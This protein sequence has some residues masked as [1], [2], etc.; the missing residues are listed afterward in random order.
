M[1]GDSGFYKSKPLTELLAQGIDTCIPDSTT[2][3]EL[4][5]D[6][7]IGTLS[8]RSRV[9]MEYDVSLDVFRCAEG[10]TLRF[11]GTKD[12]RGEETKVYEACESCLCCSRR[13]ECI[14]SKAAKT[15]YKHIIVR[16]C[17]E[18]LNAARERFNE[19]GHRE[20]YH[21]RGCMIESVFGF[22]RGAL[23]YDRW[24]LRGTERV[25]NEGKLMALG[26]QFR[27]VHKQWAAGIT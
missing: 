12:S 15:K 9:P 25:R 27:T 8:G 24:L 7:P 1:D 26:Y 4:H 11:I 5:R 14:M 16:E 21:E 18:E 2:A 20:R 10:N 6:L 19:A 23:G 3:G 22:I 17:S 13:A